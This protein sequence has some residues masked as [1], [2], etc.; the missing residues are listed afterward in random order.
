MGFEGFSEEL[1]ALAASQMALFTSEQAERLGY[2]AGDA[3]PSR[4]G[5]PAGTSVSERVRSHG[6][7]LVAGALAEGWG[8]GGTDGCMR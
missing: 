8:H 1:V 3:P 2:A 4:Q 7:R 6:R 5:R